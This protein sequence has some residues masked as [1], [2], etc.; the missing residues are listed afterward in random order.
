MSDIKFEASFFCTLT[1]ILAM[2]T[3]IGM[4]FCNMVHVGPGYTFFLLG[5]VPPRDSKIL[6]F[7]PKF[8][9]FNHE[10]LENC[11]LQSYML[12]RT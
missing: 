11:K 5:A 4:K 7:G 8:W 10:Y 3:P 6:N 9:P 2:V 12:I 1:D